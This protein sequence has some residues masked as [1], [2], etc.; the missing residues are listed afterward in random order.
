MLRGPSAGTHPLRPLEGASSCSEPAANGSGSHKHRGFHGSPAP[1]GT[2][3]ARGCGPHPGDAEGRLGQ[4]PA[5]SPVAALAP[6]R[7]LRSAPAA[8]GWRARWGRGAAGGLRGGGSAPAPAPNGVCRA[9][10]GTSR[11]WQWRG[12]T[13]GSGHRRAHFP[14]TAFTCQGQSQRWVRPESL[15]LPETK[16]R[17][18]PRC[19]PRSG[20]SAAL[21]RPFATANS[22]RT[23]PYIQSDPIP[24]AQFYENG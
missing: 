24:P 7:T 21:S 17:R 15:S 20:P 1:T 12:R 8:S 16:V 23:R 4:M 2:S 9:H 14:P 18:S 13:L 10:L 5:E 19:T 3:H 6:S 11:T 22:S